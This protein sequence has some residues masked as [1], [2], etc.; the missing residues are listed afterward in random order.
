MNRINEMNFFFILLLFIGCNQSNNNQ[1]IE[2][3]NNATSVSEI[4]SLAYELSDDSLF[5]M[6]C[7]KLN[8]SIMNESFFWLQ[9]MTDIYTTRKEV[10][11]SF[12]K[13]KEAVFP[14]VSDRLLLHVCIR[15]KNTIL[16]NNHYSNIKDIKKIAEDYIFNP[17]SSDRHITNFITKVDLIGDIEISKVAVFLSI[18]VKREKRLTVEEWRFY[19]KCMHEL[20]KIYENKKNEISLAKWNKEYDSLSFDQKVAVTS[21]VDYRL[22]LVFEGYCDYIE[23]KP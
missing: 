1:K 10:G 16:I 13:I 23:N 5:Y 18:D 19:F 4:V 21:V 11:W 7:N 6:L 3:I 17:D 8:D 2:R 15:N 9:T 22:Y 14:E 12:V 20:M